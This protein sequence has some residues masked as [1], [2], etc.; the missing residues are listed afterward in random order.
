MASTFTTLGIEKMATGENAGT[1]GDKTNTNL[2]IINVAVSGYVEQAVTSGGTLALSITDGAATATAQNAVIKLTGTITGNSI[3]TVPDSVEKVYIVTNGTSGAYTVQFKTAS[4]T[5]V[6]F[7]VSEKTTKLLYSD[8]T[9]IVDA[10]FSGAAD[11]EGRELILDADGDTS[12]TADTDDQ[13][14]FRVAG[15]DQ[16][17]ITNGAII[18]S[19]DNDIDLGT[20]SLEFKDAFFDGTVTADAFAG[21]LTGDVTGN[22][23][24]TAATVTTAAQSN[25]TSLGTL[26]TLTVDD[27][28]INGSTISDSG[29]FTVDGGADIILDADGGDIFFKDGGTTFGSATNTS[30]NLIIKSGT[31]TALTFSGANVTVAGDLTVSGDDITM[32]TNTAGNLLVADGTNFNSIAVSSLSEISTAASDDV[33][34][35]ID[36]SGGGLKKIARS[37]V[38]A[39]LATDSAISNV[40]EDTTPQL[41]GNLDMNGADIVTTSNATID[42][43]PNGT[44][45][46][47]VRGN[48]N[49]GAIVFNCESNSHG[50]KV[51]A[52]PHSAGVTNVMLLPDGA[53]STLVSLVATQTLTNKTLTTPVIAEIDSGSTITLDA[54]TD[55]ILDA[56]GANITLKDGGTTVLDFVLNGATDVTL[57]APGDIKF[58]ADGGDFNFLD[59]GTEILRISNSSSDVI[60]RPVVDAKDII[61]QQADGTEVA[62]IEDN[63]TFNVVTGKLAINGTAI[64]STAAELNLL[65]GVSGLVQA[66]LTKLAAVDS[67]AAELNIVDGG[68]SATST[69]LVDAD[70]LVANDA[71]TMVQVAMSDVKTYLSSA[72]FSTDDPTALAIALG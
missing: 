10:G 46:V 15:A 16:I 41:G 13:I 31:T 56:D 43:A 71:G 38:V 52:Q 44:G 64:T 8:G 27:I 65:D 11:V 33:F 63:A 29:D 42:L 20:S 58:D 18:P 5:G 59:G 2:D 39:G 25:I 23:S 60:I 54:T 26:T 49:S 69:T 67:T 4:G 62:R 12:I 40:V 51:I 61:F 68:T 53:D 37:A 28:T 70:R 6:T 35:A 19:T 66:D 32:G 22:V 3:V 17:K 14:D 36:T 7:G 34:I 50:Q 45:T 57:D 30:G 47:V 48:T 24:G 72:G 55:I 21:P 1:W 9:N